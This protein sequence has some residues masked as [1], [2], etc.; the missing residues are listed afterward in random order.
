MVVAAVALA[1][2]FLRRRR[3]AG[4]L[5]RRA[6]NFAL[7]AG[8]FFACDLALGRWDV[9]DSV[10]GLYTTFLLVGQTG[11]NLI[12]G[13]MADRFGHKFSLEMSAAAG[14]IGFVIAWWAHSPEW[15][16]VVFALLGFRFGSVV[17]SGILVVFEF[18][19]ADRQPTYVGLASTAAGLTNIVAP[20]IGA[21]LAGAG[22]GKLFIVSAAVNLL[23]FAAL[24]WGVHE[25]RFTRSQS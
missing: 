13:I 23:A 11:G 25:P 17:V 6:L 18:S 14:M 19:P 3:R 8:V 5:L 22:Y 7:L 12:A 4:A 20:F 21:A 24:R 15:Y 9:P 16:F 10:V 1:W 2:P